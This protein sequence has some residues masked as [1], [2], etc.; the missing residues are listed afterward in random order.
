[1]G[2][3]PSALD[4]GGGQRK[5]ASRPKQLQTRTDQVGGWRED[6]GCVVVT[7]LVLGKTWVRN[8]AK[9]DHSGILAHSFSGAHL[10]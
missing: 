3:S 4:P 10:L 9:A 8:S 2:V 7:E 5:I 6:G 1:M